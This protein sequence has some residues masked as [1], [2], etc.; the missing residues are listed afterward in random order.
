MVE[1][2]KIITNPNIEF[3]SNYPFKRLSNLLIKDEP[4]KSKKK[5]ILSLGEPNHK[6]PKFLKKIINQHYKA[7]ASYPPTLGSKKLNQACLNWLKRRYKFSKQFLKEDKNILQVAGTREG[8]FNIALAINPQT[9]NNKSSVTLM[10]DPFYQVYS[11]AALM[12]GSEP[13]AVPSLKENRFIPDF[14]SVNRE[15]LKRTKLIY[16]CSP[17]NPE[18]SALTLDEWKKII[19]LTREISAVLVADECYAEIYVKN[20]P[21]G[22]LEACHKMG[23]KIDNIVA[24][25]SLS[26]RSNVPGIRSG[27]VVGDS[28]IIEKYKKL[29][30]Y[31]AGQQ[32][33]PIQ[34]AAISLWNDDQH[35]EE[36][37]SKY[38]E[39][40]KLA[41]DIFKG[42]NNFYI[43][44]GGFYIWLKVGNDETFT[45][46][47]WKNHGIKV[48]P[49]SYLS[50]SAFAKSY[51][52]IALVKEKK[53]IS[54]A[55]TIIARLLEKDS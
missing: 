16:I 31:C 13:I 19:D 50:K 36:N 2:D 21:I 25:H 42:K 29:R 27:F 6:P 49:G 52:R 14:S 15:I 18:G 54:K 43:P 35:V 37:R 33:I 3:L 1:N 34:E 23:N 30:Q 10:P 17:S 26:K 53:E 12:S 9:I 11:G 48:M 39:K 44:D 20:A 22:V 55:L 45:K 32:P 38:K 40:F 8:L 47:L 5:I 4:P 7:W 24:F 51:I 46:T 28:K 41:K